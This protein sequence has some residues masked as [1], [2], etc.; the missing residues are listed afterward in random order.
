LSELKNHLNKAIQGQGN[1]V[2]IAGEAVV[3]KTRLLE[4]LKSYAREQGVDVLQGWST[5]I[6]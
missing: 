2:F 4:E 6:G 5:Q 1:T 3:G